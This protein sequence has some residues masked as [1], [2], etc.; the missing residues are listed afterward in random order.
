[1][2]LG[3]VCWPDMGGLCLGVFRGPV[4][5]LH[6]WVGMMDMLFFGGGLVIILAYALGVIHGSRF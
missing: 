6:R 4:R 5:P 2:D 1:M 3:G